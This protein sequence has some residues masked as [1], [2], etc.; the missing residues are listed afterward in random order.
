MSTRIHK[1]SAPKPLIYENLERF[2]H[3]LDKDDGPIKHSWVQQ[4]VGANY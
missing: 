4:T 2:I 3:N 1:R